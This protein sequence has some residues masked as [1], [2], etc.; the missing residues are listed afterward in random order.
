MTF[1]VLAFTLLMYAFVRRL[2]GSSFGRVLRRRDRGYGGYLSGYPPLQ[3]ALLEAGIWLP[4][5]ALGILEATRRRADSLALAG[6]DRDRAGRLVAGGA[7]ADQLLPDLSAGRVVRVSPLANAQP[8][9]VSLRLPL[10]SE[11]ES[12]SR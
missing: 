5:A 1:H 7:S 3:L 10:G 8:D 12:P 9:P 4:L 11:A 6:R 2:T